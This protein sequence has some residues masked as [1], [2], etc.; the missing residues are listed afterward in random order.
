MKKI[1]LLLIEDNRFLREGIVELLQTGVS[2]FILMNTKISDFVK[3]IRMVANEGIAKKLH[4]STYTI[5]SNL[6]NIME[7]LTLHSRDQTTKY[8]YASKHTG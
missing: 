5:K 8:A 1:R 3:T 6:F 4:I 2:G 7:K